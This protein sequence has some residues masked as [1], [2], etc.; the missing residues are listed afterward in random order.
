MASRFVFGRAWAHLA[1]AAAIILVSLGG[2]AVAQP[3]AP[4]SDTS[5]YLIGPGDTLQISVWHNPE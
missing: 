1:A 2:L 5:K 4:A 3:A